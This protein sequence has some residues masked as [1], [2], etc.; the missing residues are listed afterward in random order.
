MAKQ[1]IILPIEGMSCAACAQTVQQ[2]LGATPGVAAASV[3]YAT[4]K[5]AV[6]Y[7]DAQTGVGRLA[8]AVRDAGYQCGQA[9]VTFT[10]ADLHYAPSTAGLESELAA[11]PGVMR[12]VAN[13]A[14]EAVTVTY[15]P[16]ITTADQ[17]EEAVRT[18][19]FRVSEPIA[20]EDPVERERLARNREIRTL[21]WQLS[22]RR[23]G[24]AAHHARRHAADGGARRRWRGHRPGGPAGAAAHAAGRPAAPRLRRRRTRERADASQADAGRP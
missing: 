14:T 8:K 23:D 12:A 22:C 6:D 15:V 9:S 1:R 4:A 7:D 19:G 5:A 10:I 11:V 21:T 16:G 18:A 2:A 20:A 24:R 3:N 13:Q 17:L